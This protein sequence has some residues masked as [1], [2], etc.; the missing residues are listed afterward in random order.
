MAHNEV[1]D[2]RA[3]RPCVHTSASTRLQQKSLPSTVSS[4]AHQQR[5]RHPV[6][7]SPL[8]NSPTNLGTQAHRDIIRLTR[9]LTRGAKILHGV[10]VSRGTR[11][12]GLPINNG[13]E[14]LLC[15]IADIHWGRVGGTSRYKMMIH[16]VLVC[17]LHRMPAQ[18][19]SCTADAKAV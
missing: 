14:A 1:R 5:P 8:Q 11:R 10:V 2:G 19:M 13:R 15:D 7:P 16:C 12:V 9:Q 4:C 18:V 17:A 6:P 3:P